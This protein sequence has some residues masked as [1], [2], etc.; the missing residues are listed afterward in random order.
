MNKDVIL[1]LS[2]LFTTLFYNRPNDAGFFPFSQVTVHLKFGCASF[3]MGKYTGKTARLIC[4]LVLTFGFFL[5]EIIYGYLTN[6]LALVS[7]SYHM[8]SDVV[9]LV[10]GLA[11]VR[12]STLI[13]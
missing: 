2:E 3:K 8:L 7:D 11:A 4:M 5:V 9:A 10:V 1:T 12:V 13:E 6:S